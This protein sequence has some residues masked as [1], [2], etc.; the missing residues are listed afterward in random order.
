MNL[1]FVSYLGRNIFCYINVLNVFPTSARGSLI[2]TNGF[3]NLYS[4][5][6]TLKSVDKDLSTS[7]QQR[8]TGHTHLL[9]KFKGLN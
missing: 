8:I 7:Q 1:L 4:D 9:G 2:V 6:I 3:V 5:S